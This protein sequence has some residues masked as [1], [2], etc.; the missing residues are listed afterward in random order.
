MHQWYWSY[1]YTDYETESGDVIEFDVRGGMS[2]YRG[3]SVSVHFYNM[4]PTLTLV[5]GESPEMNIAWLL[6]A[7]L[8]EKQLTIT[9]LQVGAPMTMTTLLKSNQ[10][11]VFCEG[12]CLDCKR[13]IKVSTDP[14]RSSVEVDTLAHSVFF[15]IFNILKINKDLNRSQFESSKSKGVLRVIRKNAGLPKGKNIY[16]NGV[17]IVPVR[18]NYLNFVYGRPNSLRKG[19][20]TFNLICFKKFYST[21]ST[22]LL[23]KENNVILKLQSLSVRTS[24]FPNDVV[25]RNLIQILCKP[26]FLTMVY[27]NLNINLGSC[28]LAP[29]LESHII[30]GQLFKTIGEDIKKESFQ[31]MRMPKIS[32]SIA[33]TLK[34]RTHLENQ[35]LTEE[36]LKNIIVF[37]AIKLFLEIVFCWAGVRSS[38]LPMLY[39]NSLLFQSVRNEFNELGPFKNFSSFLLKPGDNKLSKARILDNPSNVIA[40]LLSNIKINNSQR[41]IVGD[42]SDCL[43]NL[44]YLKLMQIIENKILDRTFTKLL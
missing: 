5:E 10:K 43:N 26:E 39:Q 29:G 28:S 31:F 24:K 4:Y 25:D 3:D 32:K 12:H 19:S 9:V 18:N 27:K 15:L 17:T 42:L 21:G 33:S 44:N 41:V 1:E 40:S 11:A 13:T 30:S 36:L 7:I 35:P 16:G 34:E 2:N 22:N 23:Y 37:E 14:C 6:K 38:S 8:V 20:V